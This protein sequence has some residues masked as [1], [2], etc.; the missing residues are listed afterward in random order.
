MLEGVWYGIAAALVFFGIVCIAYI[1]AARIFRTDSC[2][3]LVVLLSPEADRCD[4]G[5]LLYAAHMKLALW[6]NCCSGSIILVD[7]GLNENQLQLCRRI[8]SECGSMEMCR[9][10]ALADVLKADC[11]NGKEI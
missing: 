2:G 1:I 9:A 10:D 5:S 11:L 4:I 8:M 6:G 7:N 3:R